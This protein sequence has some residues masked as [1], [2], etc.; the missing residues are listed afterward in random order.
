[1]RNQTIWVDFLIYTSLALTLLSIVLFSV[2]NYS[3]FQQLKIKLN[4]MERSLISIYNYLSY[5]SD[6]YICSEKFTLDIPDNCYMIITNNTVT[7][8]CLSY[9]FYNFTSDRVYINITKR[10]NIYYYNFTIYFYN[11]TSNLTLT[12]RSCIL[13]NK[14]GSSITLNK[15]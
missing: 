13:F 5:V 8:I 4:Y 6:C 10:D 11:F 3:D 1:M 12:G 15:C 9:K 2:K 14:T 7:S